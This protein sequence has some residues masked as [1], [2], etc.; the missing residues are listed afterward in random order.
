MRLQLHTH[1]FTALTFQEILAALREKLPDYL[2]PDPI[3]GQFTTKFSE[4][5]QENPAFFS[6][7]NIQFLFYFADRLPY[8]LLSLQSSTKNNASKEVITIPDELEPSGDSKMVQ[9][10][11]QGW[12]PYQSKV[13]TPQVLI[14]ETFPPNMQYSHWKESQNDPK[15][16]KQQITI[17]H[18]FSSQS[19]PK[20]DKE[21]L[22]KKH[23]LPTSSE[24]PKKKHKNK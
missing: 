13:V 6:G 21:L 14:V 5:S 9:P 1:R 12:T 23:P 18:Y 20:T 7:Q 2:T 22:H 10:N 24:P 4:V 11:N 15:S 8:H 3:S 19:L 17:S 16:Q